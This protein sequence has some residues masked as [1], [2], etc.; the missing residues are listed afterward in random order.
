MAIKNQLFGAHMS[1]AGGFQNAFAA[2]ANAGCDCLQIFVKNQR[3]WSAPPLTREAVDAYKSAEHE[4]GIGPV[5]A[6]AS[7]LLNLASPEKENVKR[8]VSALID[9]I[10]R[11][12]QLG[13]P[14][15]V[16]HPGAHMGE[17]VD[18][19]IKRIVGGLNEVHKKAKAG[20]VQVL[21]E[22]TAGQGTSIGHEIEH[23]GRILAGVRNPDSLGVC[24]DTC[25]VFAAGY[26][27]TSDAGYEKLASEIERFVG[28]ERVKCIHV[29][30][31][32]RPCGSR[33]DRHDH[34]GKG[35]IGLGGFRRVLNDGRLAHAMRILETPKGVDGR[36]TDLDKVNLRR[37]RKLITE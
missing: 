37:L 12:A 14:N 13:V 7:Y 33:V 34:I 19:G 22:T 3:Q 5:V 9:E 29:N 36:G 27:L 2:A 6:H 24:V 10:E 1:V 4:T 17:G 23:L 11:C 20:S 31:S 18:A 21:L 26:D 25:H 30:D 8:S 28:F 35:E 16:F 15:L 32:L